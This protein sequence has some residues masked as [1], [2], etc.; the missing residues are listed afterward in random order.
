MSIKPRNQRASTKKRLA[1]VSI[2]SV[3]I[4]NTQFMHFPYLLFFFS[5]IDSRSHLNNI[6]HPESMTEEER[7]LNTQEEVTPETEQEGAVIK[8]ERV[9]SKSPEVVPIIPEAA[10]GSSSQT[11]PEQD[12]AVPGRLHPLPPQILRVKPH[13]PADVRPSERP[14][15]SFIP[16]D[17]K[18]KREAG[19]EIQTLSHDKIN[20]PNKC[21]MTEASSDQLSNAHSSAVALRSSS[22]HQPGE[23]EST[24]VIKRPAAGSGSFH[25]SITTAKNRDGERPRSGSFVGVL[26]QIE[27]RHKME[28]KPFSSMKEKAEL[29]D[30]Q[31]RGGPFAVGR[32]RQEGAAHKSAVLP[33]DKRESFKKAETVAPSKNVTPAT[34]AAEEKE[35]ESSQELVEEAVEAREV[36]EDEGK[37]AFG[38]KLRSTSQ[39]TRLRSDASSNLTSKSPVCQEQSEKHKRHE[40]S[41]NA[42]N[43]SK[44]LRTSISSTPSASGD[45]QLAGESLRNCIILPCRSCL[46][47][48]SSNSNIKVY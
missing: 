22:A 24:R 46:R 29:R 21:G 37:T 42:G 47:G 33:W 34:G 25:F 31:P 45:P 14:H 13:R 8:S 15:S 11:F 5:Q 44:N 23:T 40:V 10:T 4:N 1:A 18:D 38:I 43:M 26:E 30:S 2:L 48:C 7:P 16:S 9:P 32:L 36:E 3:K 27:A 39:S 6:D 28:E 35:V 19:F 17:V 20:T 12:Q 41:D